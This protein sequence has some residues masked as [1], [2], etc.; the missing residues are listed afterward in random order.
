MAEI[1]AEGVEGSGAAALILRE[2]VAQAS[3]PDEV[4]GVGAVGDA[5]ALVN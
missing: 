1:G 3:A 2:P 4:E 5:K